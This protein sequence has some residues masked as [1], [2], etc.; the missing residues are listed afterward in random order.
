MKKIP[1]LLLTILCLFTTI[2]AQ[3]FEIKNYDVKAT[4]NRDAHVVEVQTKLRLVN[5]SGRELADKVLLATTNKPRLSFYLH[6]KAKVTAMSVNGATVQF[7]TGEPPRLPLIT[8]ATDI[9]SSFASAPEFD[10]ELTY[11]IPST[12]RSQTLH[13]STGENYALPNGFWVPMNHNPYADHGVD[14]A[15]FTITVNAPG[16]K[17]VSSGNRTSDNVYE[18]TLAAQPFFF[19]GNYDVTSVTAAKSAKIEIYAPRGLDENG[20]QQIKRL[21]DEATNIVNFYTDYFGVPQ[22]GAFRIIATG[23]TGLTFSEPGAVAIDDSYF[24]RNVLDLGTIELIT[25]A[26][27]KSFI[28]GRVLMRGRGAGFMRDGLPIYLVA[29][30]LGARYGE[31][32]QTAA[33]DRYRRAYE[34]VARGSDAALLQQTP[35][36]RS[37]TTVVYNKGALV[38]RLIEKK[39]GKAAFDKLVRSMLDRQRVDVLS[40]TE[41][42]A[43]LCRAARCTSVKADLL[44]A[45][46][47]QS[48]AIQEVFTQW[49]ENV[50]VPD[51]AVGQPQAGASGVESTLVNFGSGDIAVDIVATTEAGEKLNRTVL[52]KGGEYGAVTFPAG[53]KIARIEVDPDKLYPQKDYSNDVFPRR[54]AP[55][56]A[57]GQAS[58]AFTKK[59]YATAETKLKE[60]L[61]AEPNAP[62][63]QALLGRVLLATNKTAEATKAFADTL[64]NQPIPLQ[65]FAWAQ[66]GLGQMALQA[67]KYAEAATHFRLASASELDQATT[68]AAR[69]G[70]IKAEQGANAVKVPEEARA[71]LKQLDEALLTGSPD[72]VNPL[73]EQGNLREFVKRVTG[74]K[75][76]TWTTEILRAEVWDADRI[77]VDT[78]VK[79]KIIGREG[80]GRAVY[81]L[82]R[83]SG[84]W[85]LSDVPI[86][87]VK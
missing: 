21:A 58:L 15:P 64:K 65:A 67:N 44:A 46:G 19:A 54:A 39:I 3:E 32:Q 42:K 60:A 63:L 10:V 61:S 6:N 14:T 79:V 83:A 47:T 70:A 59:D 72:A 34:P 50:V 23:T 66:L 76:T 51:F 20:Q 77:A 45:A 87:D 35:Y 16:S 25:A 30:Y 7:R 86:F 41:W 53:T 49:I 75:P 1:I 33:F 9:T 82:S 78:N 31:A 24:R 71:F 13:V 12:D 38:W 69:D 73:V 80:V 43:P 27:A 17:I 18:Q 56:E 62:I 29:Q 36:D 57:Y 4:V 85:K 55:N 28:D 2:R 26:A 5:L 81:V 11:A 52:V 22:P 40:L 37:Y 48:D 84:K 74:S 8:V 68:L